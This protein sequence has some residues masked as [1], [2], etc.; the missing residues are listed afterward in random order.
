MDHQAPCY[1]VFLH[2][3]LLRKSY[4][5]GVNCAPISASPD[6]GPQAL[7]GRRRVFPC[8]AA[9]MPTARESAIAQA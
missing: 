2:V 6:P 5:D 3:A 1:P 4:K 7:G 9:T 8:M